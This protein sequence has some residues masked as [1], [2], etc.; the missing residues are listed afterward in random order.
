MTSVT[1][2]ESIFNAHEIDCMVTSYLIPLSHGVDFVLQKD[3]HPCSHLL[4]D[5]SYH[6]LKHLAKSLELTCYL[7]EKFLLINVY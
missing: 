4:S 7:E 5:V 6:L 3:S 2:E 1:A